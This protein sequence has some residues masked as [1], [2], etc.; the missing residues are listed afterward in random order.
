VPIVPR[1][2]VDQTLI[3]SGVKR[4]AAALSPDVVRIRYSLGEDWSGDPSIFFRVVLSDDASRETR[5]RETT[6]RAATEILKEVA[7]E[8]LGLQYYFNFRSLSEQASFNEEAWA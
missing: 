5:L 7:V 1:G 2:F 4:A 6:R 8:E 3:A